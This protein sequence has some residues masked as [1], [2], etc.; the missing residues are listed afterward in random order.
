MKG[1]R[2]AK[3]NLT[4]FNLSPRFYGAKKDNTSRESRFERMSET[5]LS[6]TGAA[7]S[8]RRRHLSEASAGGIRRTFVT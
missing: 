4:L 6:E 3:A 1:K 2:G 7:V 5:A 8:V